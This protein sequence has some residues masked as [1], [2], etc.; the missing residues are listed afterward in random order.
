MDRISGGNGSS[1]LIFGAPAGSALFTPMVVNPHAESFYYV[2]MTGVS[3]GGTRVAGVR[4]EDFRLDTATGKGGVVVDSGTSV[5][6][7]VGPAYV[8]LRDAFRTGAAGLGETRNFSLFDTCYDLSGM[9]EVRVP[10]VVLHFKGDGGAA[11]ADMVLPAANYMVP[12]TNDPVFCFAFASSEELSIIG[13]I[14]QQ[15]FRVVF[16]GDGSRVGFVPNSC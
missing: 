9:T 11:G 5:T 13:N 6:R 12:V 4:A 1:T 2:E 14:Q 8:A 10:T 15:G 7:L 16:D 3:V